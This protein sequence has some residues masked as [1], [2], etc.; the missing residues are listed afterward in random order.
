[1]RTL[2][3]IQLDIE[4]LSK[5]IFHNDKSKQEKA[6]YKLWKW[7]PASSTRSSFIKIFI[8]NHNHLRD[9]KSRLNQSNSE[10][11]DSKLNER[12]LE[13]V[14][15]YIEQEKEELDWSIYRIAVSIFRY[16]YRLATGKQSEYKLL[17]PQLY[18]ELKNGYDLPKDM[19]LDGE[20]IWKKIPEYPEYQV[21]N[22]GR[23]MSYMHSSDGRLLKPG[24]AA[25]GYLT[26]GL[27]NGKR[28]SFYVHSLVANAFLGHK[29]DGH[30]IVV[31]HVNR[32]KLDNRLENI[33]V[34]T[35][36]ENTSNNRKGT[37]SEYVGV[38]WSKS[39][40]KWQANIYVN[41]N[42]ESL[43]YFTDEYEA[44]L[45][46]EKRLKEINRIMI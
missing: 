19:L 3:Q 31:S 12:E 32:D 39:C 28:K 27:T 2:E 41:G 33:R 42:R 10:N 1:M 7:I 8:S 44:H 38:G 43:G 9:L 25:K 21:S 34:V 35:N 11:D 16:E 30:K 36:R 20:E 6:F 46:Y 45:A 13:R 23:V 26:V 5:D 14:K 17:T 22:Y 18:K 40:N 37:S 29:S 15:Y 24:I 4:E